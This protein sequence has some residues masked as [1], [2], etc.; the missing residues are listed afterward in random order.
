MSYHNN[1]NYY[2]VHSY[3]QPY[4][5]W[6]RG[7]RKSVTL[8]SST[9]WW[10]QRARSHAESCVTSSQST[11]CPWWTRLAVLG[12]M[13]PSLE[14][15]FI[16]LKWVLKNLSSPFQVPLP[17]RYSLYHSSEWQL[18]S[19]LIHYFIFKHVSNYTSLNRTVAAHQ[20]RCFQGQI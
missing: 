6:W 2:S 10:R 17:P 14:V 3:C 1:A 15:S 9:R 12:P 16:T 19:I 5:C 13:L 8:G 20:I 7:T 18:R 4:M 11:I